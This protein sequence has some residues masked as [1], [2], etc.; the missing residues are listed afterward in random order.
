M[1]NNPAKVEA[2]ELVGIKVAERISADVPPEPSSARYLQTKR[3]KMGH[4]VS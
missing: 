3:E 2:L 4:L 1:T